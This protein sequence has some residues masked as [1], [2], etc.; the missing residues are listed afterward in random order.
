MTK[1]LLADVLLFFGALYIP[2]YVFLCVGA[3][4]SFRFKYYAEFALL[5][6]M[7]D[8]LYG[9]PEARFFVFPYVY[10]VA[11]GFI[12]ILASALR[13]RLFWYNDL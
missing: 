13:S 3:Y 12:I 6:L 10:F 4:L 8:I 1:R 9:V 2:W 7:L 11:S 5:A